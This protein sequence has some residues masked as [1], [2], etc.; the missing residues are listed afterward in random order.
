M[1]LINLEN[2]QILVQKLRTADTF[3][4]RFLGLMFTKTLPADCGLHLRP[5]KG[6]HTFFM[7]Y[8]IDVLHL[9]E[10]HQVIFLEEDVSPGK[11][12]KTYPRTWEI[13]ELPSG[14]IRETATA[15]GHKLQFSEK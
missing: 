13:I 5:C 9:D 7:R 3:V 15:V 11:V 14:K 4:K 10:G 2:G 6:I 8:N 1:K 12:G